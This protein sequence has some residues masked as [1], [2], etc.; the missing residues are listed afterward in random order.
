MSAWYH[1]MERR[2]P[3]QKLSAA[4]KNEDVKGRRHI[5]GDVYGIKPRWKREVG[6]AEG[7]GGG[8]GGVAQFGS[9]T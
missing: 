7:E 4:H 5:K 9:G 6:R 2:Q 8:G 1:S 3:P